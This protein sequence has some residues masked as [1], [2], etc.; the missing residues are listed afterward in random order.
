MKRYT[1]DI[2]KPEDYRNIIM[3]IFPILLATYSTVFMLISSQSGMTKVEKRRK[4]GSKKKKGN[5][6]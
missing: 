6:R 2:F 5:K 1:D 4:K 3:S